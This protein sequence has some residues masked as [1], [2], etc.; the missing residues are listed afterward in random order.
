MRVLLGS[1]DGGPTGRAGGDARSLT[2]LPGIGIPYVDPHETVRQ[3]AKG[4]QLPETIPIARTQ[5]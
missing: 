4:R 1:T 3:A 5:A 2:K